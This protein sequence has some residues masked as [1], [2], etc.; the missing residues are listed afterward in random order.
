MSLANLLQKNNIKHLAS[1][2]G[3]FGAGYCFNKMIQPKPTVF[4]W[5]EKG[6]ES[7]INPSK[8]KFI[9]TKNPKKKSKPEDLVFGA[10]YTDHMLEIDWVRNSGFSVPRIVPFHDFVMPPG[11]CTIHYAL[12][13]FEGLKAYRDKNNDIRLFRPDRNVDRLLGSTKRLS[14]PGFN[15]EALLEAM[16]RYVDVERSWVP[17]KRGYSLYL[18]PTVFGTEATLGVKE[19]SS[20]KIFVIASPVGPYYKHGFK[21]VRLLAEDKYCRAWEGGTGNFKLGSNYGPTILP[22]KLAHDPKIFGGCDQ[23]LWLYGPKKEVTEVGTMN[24][25]GFWINENQEK[26]LITAPLTDGTI[27]PG[28]TRDS[29]LNIAREWGEFKVT[30]RT[31]TMEELLKAQKEK[32][33]LEVFGSGTAAI[34][35]PVK[36]I[37]YQDQLYEIPR[38]PSD[39]KAEMGPITKRLLDRI[40]SIQYGEVQHPWSQVVKKH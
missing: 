24:L 38:N 9:K 13:C 2:L 19:P 12:T 8:L 22:Q 36:E 35:S 15:K 1:A 27:L 30:E 5:I 6:T 16:M 26:E 3:A 25:F 14:L 40:Q 37:V 21:A 20:M 39:P 18:R 32:R 10:T 11:C 29:I 34:V 28:I 33:I 31:W 7:D 4:P 17:N 23:V